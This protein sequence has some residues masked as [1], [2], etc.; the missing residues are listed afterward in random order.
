MPIH[1]S[2]FVE[3]PSTT[4]TPPNTGR[5]DHIPTPTRPSPAS[6]DALVIAAALTR[7]NFGANGSQAHRPEAPGSYTP[8]C[9]AQST[10]G[11]ERTGAYVARTRGIDPCKTCF[12]SGWG[13]AA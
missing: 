3:R 6:D 11:W 9:G 10:E 8:A 13:W 4:T 5:W 1:R 7:F 12:Q 2:R